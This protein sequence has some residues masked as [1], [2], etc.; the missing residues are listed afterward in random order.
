[1]RVIES[2]KSRY[3]KRVINNFGSSRYAEKLRRFQNIHKGE[4]CF[5]IGNGPSLSAG[6]LQEI[7]IKKIPSFA[8]NRIYFMFEKT[9]WRP[10]YYVSQDQKTLGGCVNEVNEMDLRY[11]FIPLN[12]KYYYKIKINKAHY[13]KLINPQ[14][15]I[16]ELFED[17]SNGIGNSN[18][19]TITAMQLAVYMGFK[20][21]YLLGVD[22][23]FSTYTNDKGEIIND[24]SVKDYFT[25]KYNPDQAQLYMPNLDKSTRDFIIAKKFCEE[26]GVKVYNATRGGK[27]EVFPRVDF[28]EIINK[29]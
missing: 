10:T 1:M 15:D 13:F 21:I 28:D 9:S 8:F 19:V 12:F 26:H 25:D 18:T 7:F 17:I 2:L 5:I 24:N 23:N 22:H 6:D 4:Q 11:K 27:L 20:E 3:K 29:L 16:I 14:T